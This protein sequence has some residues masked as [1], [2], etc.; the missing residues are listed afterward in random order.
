MNCLAIVFVMDIDEYLYEIVSVIN[1]DWARGMSEEDDES[2]A[3]TGHAKTDEEDE[4]IQRLNEEIVIL[5]V[6]LN[7]LLEHFP[8]IEKIK[9]IPHKGQAVGLI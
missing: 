2:F 3:E 9:A 6:K 4:I 1:D 5:K 7:Q 8:K